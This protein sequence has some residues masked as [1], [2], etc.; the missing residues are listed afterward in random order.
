MLEDECH[1]FRGINKLAVV[2]ERNLSVQRVRHKGLAFQFAFT[3]R[4]RV[5]LPGIPCAQPQSL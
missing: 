5:P 1:Q 4:C 3:A 2:G